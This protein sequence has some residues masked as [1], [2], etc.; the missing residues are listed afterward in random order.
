[1]SK[2]KNRGGVTTTGAQTVNVDANFSRP[3]D[4]T[5]YAAG[6]VVSNATGTTHTYITF[7]NCAQ[8]LG[9]SG[10]IVSAACVS[11]TVEA[12]KPDF[13]LFIFDTAPTKMEDNAAFDPTDAEMRTVVGV[14]AFAQANWKQGK[15]GA[16]GTGNS[17]CEGSTGVYGFV[18]ASAS[19]DLYGVL[20]ER[21][22][23]T[24]IS[25]ERFDF[26]LD[27]QQD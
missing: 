7:S 10:Q 15:A 6:D 19:K 23:Y 1:M 9:G 17:R 4:T 11:S 27:I 21:A 12:T 22:T 13:E 5:Q 3:A 25:A 24:P 8:A 14:I 16:T 2:G 20:V 18:C 26:R